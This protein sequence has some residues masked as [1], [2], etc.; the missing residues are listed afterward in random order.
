MSA[1]PHW[2]VPAYPLGLDQRTV[3]A[4]RE[5][6]AALAA[7]GST[8]YTATV[9]AYDGQIRVQ[10]KGAVGGP[11][12]VRESEFDPTPLSWTTE[13]AFGI[14]FC[15]SQPAALLHLPVPPQ[16]AELGL[17]VCPVPGEGTA[18]CARCEA[19]EPRI[20]MGPC[21]CGGTGGCSYCEECRAMATE[22]IT[23]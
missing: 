19:D 9:T 13:T 18:G 22:E 17:C 7:S 23:S 20:P 10:G 4:L 1:P 3:N 8:V 15:A 14:E 2:G 16:A 5:L 11:A 21:L 12:T 6:A